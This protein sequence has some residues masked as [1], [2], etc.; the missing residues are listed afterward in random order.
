MEGEKIQQSNL[1]IFRWVARLLAGAAF[2]FFLVVKVVELTLPDRNPE[3]WATN[4]LL[5]L[6]YFAFLLISIIIGWRHE[7]TGG[8]LLTILALVGMVRLILDTP[9]DFAVSIFL[10]S[11]FL[12][13]GIFWMIC[14]RIQWTRGQEKVVTLRS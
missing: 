6:I 10:L 3:K 2:T 14:C 7:R 11:P 5:V 9:Q 1:T 13:S 12:V 4:P 8:I